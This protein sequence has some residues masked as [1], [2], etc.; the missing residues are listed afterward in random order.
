M[1][2]NEWLL[3]AETL[4]C[5]GL[6]LSIWRLD[7]ERLLGVIAI[8]LILITTVG[9]KII[10]VFG[11]ETNAGNVFY[12]ALFLATYLLV[13]RHGRREGVRAVGWGTLAVVAYLALVAFSVAFTG[14]GATATFDT[15]LFTVFDQ[16]PRI[17]LAS[18][19]AYVV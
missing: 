5:T 3:L 7:K 9:G 2:L 8:S 4:I 13:E 11:Y 1:G 15:A 18:I 10:T 17:A 14:S 19:L 6:V 16:V 12:A